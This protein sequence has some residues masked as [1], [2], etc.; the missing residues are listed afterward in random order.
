[1][2]KEEEEKKKNT[3]ERGNRVF[4]GRRSGEGEGGVEDQGEGGAP[5]HQKQRAGG[6]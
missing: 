3:T 5:F 1:M 4:R 2:K 6:A